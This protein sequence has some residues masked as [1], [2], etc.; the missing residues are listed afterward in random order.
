MYDD[1]ALVQ[2]KQYIGGGNST[3]SPLRQTRR[4]QLHMQREQLA[5]RLKHVDDALTALDAHPELEEFI[6][7]MQRANV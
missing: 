3:G 4:Q 1:M 2:E 5:A 6:E 7:T